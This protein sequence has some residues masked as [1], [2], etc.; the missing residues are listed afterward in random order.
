[1]FATMI[2]S[3]LLA[4]TSVIA[5]EAVSSQNDFITTEPISSHQFKITYSVPFQNFTLNEDSDNSACGLNLNGEIQ[6]MANETISLPALLR[7]VILPPGK[8]LQVEVQSNRSQTASLEKPGENFLPQKSLDILATSLQQQDINLP[9][10]VVVV[11]DEENFR[12]NR[13]VPVTFFPILINKKSN[14]LEHHEEVEV[15]FEFIDAPDDHSNDLSRKTPRTLTKDTYSYLNAVALNP[16]KRDDNG[17]GLPRGGYLIVAG[18]ISRNRIEERVNKLADWKRAC[19]HHVEISWDEHNPND[20]LNDFIEPAYEEW[21]PPLE[22]VCLIGHYNN[23][24]APGTYNDI[25]FGL[26]EGR[27][28]ISEVAV[29]RISGQSDAQVNVAIERILG[30]QATPW[31]EEMDWFNKAGAGQERLGGWVPSV[32]FT[33]QWIVEAERRAGFDPVW[34]SFYN[35]GGNNGGGVGNWIS[36]NA[37]IIITRG[38]YYA[39]GNYPNDETYPMYITVGGGHTEQQWENMWI[40]GT[41]NRLSGPSAMTGTRHAPQTA[42]CNAIAGAMARA[43]L[44]EHLPIGWARAFAM[45]MLDYGGVQGNGWG[46]YEREFSMYAEPS[47][48]VW[49]GTP[50]VMDVQHL[51]TLSTGQKLLQVVVTDE[52]NDDPVANAFVSLTQPGDLLIWGVTNVEGLCELRLEEDWEEE[53]I[54]SVTGD[55][56]FPYQTTLEFDNEPLFFTCAISEFN[57]EDGNEDGNLNPGETVQLRIEAHNLSTETAAEDV[58]GTVICS[59][60]WVEIE[61]ANLEFGNINAESTG[62]AEDWVSVTLMESAV[63]MANIGLQILVESGEQSWISDLELES[64]APHYDIQEIVGGAIL[65]PGVQNFNIR[66]RNSGSTDSPEIFAELS[67]K[68]LWIQIIDNETVFPEIQINRNSL[69]E[70]AFRINAI[71]YAVPGTIAHMVLL[72]KCNADDIPDT[73][74]FDLQIDVPGE[75]KPMGPDGYGYVCFDNT[76]EFW[77]ISPRFNWIEI[78]PENDDRDFDGEELPGNR[79]ENF[80]KVV[81]LPFVF[82]YYGE[83]FNEITICENGFISMGDLEELGQYDNYPIDRNMCGSFGMIAPYWDGVNAR[84]NDRNIYRYYDEDENIFIIEWCDVRTNSGDATFEIILYDPEHYPVVSGDGNILFQYL[85]VPNSRANPPPNYF[86]TG[87][88][89][90]DGRFGLGY[91]SDNEYH[92]SAAPIEN[93]SAILFSTSPVSEKGVLMGRVTDHLDGTPIS[94]A[95]V[96]TKYGQVAISNEEGNWIIEDAWALPFDITAFKQGYNDSTQWDFDIEEDDTLVINFDLLHPEFI[97]SRDAFFAQIELNEAIEIDFNIRNTGNGPLNWWSE[98]MLRGDANADPWHFRRNYYP[99]NL[100]DDAR[101]QGLVFANEHYYVSGGNDR[102]PTFYIFN[103][104]FEL[105][106]TLSQPEAT[107]G[108]TKGLR[109]LAWDG[110]LI[111]GCLRDNVYGINL[112]GEVVQE[113]QAEYNP[114]V[115]I[116]WDKDREVLWTTATVNNPIAYTRD[117][118]RID[119]LEVNRRGLRIYGLGYYPDEPNGYN[120]FLFHKEIETN[121]QT[122]HKFNPETNDSMF[123]CYLNH[124]NGGVPAGAFITNQLDVYSWVFMCISD[125]SVDLGGDRIDIWQ[126]DGRRDWFDLSPV[127]GVLNQGE[128]Q[129]FILTLDATDLPLVR[130][131]ADYIFHHNADDGLFTIPITLDVFNES[132]ELRID[133]RSG[134]NLISSN[135]IPVAPDIRAVFAP[136]VENNQLVLVKDG[137]GRFYSPV[138]NFTNIGDWQSYNGYQVF[139][140][141]VTELNMRGT[142]I[143]ADEPIQLEM[144]WNMISYY[145]HLELEAQEAFIGIDDRMI[146]AKDGS[147]NFYIPEYRYSNMATMRETRGYQVKMTENAEL[148]YNQARDRHMA[149]KRQIL[150]VK[151]FPKVTPTSDNMSVLILGNPLYNGWEAGIFSEDGSCF[152][153]GTFNPQGRCG[154]AVWGGENASIEGQGFSPNEEMQFRIWNGEEEISVLLNPVAGENNWQAD[155]ILIAKL[156]SENSVAVSFGISE[157][158]PNPTN[159]PMRLSF[160]LEKPGVVKLSIYDLM[161]RQVSVLLNE[162]RSAG[163]HQTFWDTELTSSGVYLIRLESERKVNIIKAAVIK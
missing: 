35:A 109:D 103:R 14:E 115:A 130:F 102:C 75:G 38:S 10:K 118:E 51:E 11:A 57:D 20:I 43:L 94:D 111:W 151:H 110:E 83:D 128:Q 116:T 46:F 104:D 131:E 70:S 29:G 162:Q 63:E 90:P 136:L 73:I 88:S 52:D 26:I 12:G 31:D 159:G 82:T 107:M 157:A 48:K 39:I 147:G 96:L 72:L 161:G 55:T 127:S 15:S 19:G 49:R 152:G 17:D 76:D 158:F 141:E 41:L 156:D 123:V 126:I 13:L 37:N 77:E 153:S 21:D 97:E 84:G 92:D 81:D 6:W 122:L 24:Q 66:L 50:T 64:L 79:P 54:L 3:T 134:W 154:M 68:S 125:A 112:Q 142:I 143:R 113:W 149:A 121:R 117:G 67:T 119:S 25:Q 59:N 86:S 95:L 56:L 146:I 163:L 105:I 106:D 33:V 138:D 71:A 58:S 160:G 145:P 140:N 47:Q 101:I 34:W 4:F 124:E 108:D 2:L 78:D 85:E 44:I 40:Q 98:D 23:C 42:P 132:R 91:T 53:I 28:H 30:Y 36:N 114:T 69:P 9:D 87:I 22:F 7:Y 18:N 133:L 61:N 27:D 16:P 60:P 155:E 62:E 100:V 80:T 137:D 1:M 5:S 74:R 120:L 139:T 148:I 8:Q 65:E 93:R 89:S 150:S 99:A 144:G 129:D 32:N 45:S 135:T